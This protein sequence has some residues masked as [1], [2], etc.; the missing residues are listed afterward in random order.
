MTRSDK[1]TIIAA[2]AAVIC[3]AFIFTYYSTQYTE[4]Y[5]SLDEIT[6]GTYA[7]C[8]SVHSSF[9]PAKYDVVKVSCDNSVHTFKGDVYISFIDG[10]PY[11]KVKDYNLVDVDEIRLYV[12][13]GSVVYQEAITIRN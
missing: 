3:G 8:Y 2:L 5:Y 9:E 6:D 4:H 7:I 1:I 10:E 13:K 12:P 11:A